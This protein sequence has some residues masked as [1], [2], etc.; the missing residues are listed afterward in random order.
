[1]HVN[2]TAKVIASFM[3]PD[4]LAQ[5]IYH[6]ASYV[7][8]SMHSRIHLWVNNI[9]AFIGLMCLF[10]SKAIYCCIKVANSWALAHALLIVLL[11]MW[12]QR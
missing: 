5:S 11:C 8:I 9:S 12:L 1:M 7:I 3:S 6:I 2:S 4:P 10:I